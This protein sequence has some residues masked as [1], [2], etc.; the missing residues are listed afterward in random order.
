MSSKPRSA[1][2]PFKNDCLKGKV[3]FVTGGGSGIGFEIARQF[4]LH[5]PCA[6]IIGTPAHGPSQNKTK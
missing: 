3:A 6:R 1:V 5:G 2:S 4:G